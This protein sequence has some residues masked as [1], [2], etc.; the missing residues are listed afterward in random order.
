[1]NGKT[2][3]GAL[4][5][6]IA[7]LAT[8]AAVALAAPDLNTVATNRVH[9]MTATMKVVDKETNYDELKRMGGA[10]ATTYRIKKMDF[11]YKF[12]DKARFEA[13][14]LGQSVLLVYNGDMK[15]SKIPFRKDI[16]NVADEPG[17][18]QSLMDLGVF[19]RDYLASAYRPVYQ[20]TEN[21]FYV[22]KLEQRNTTNTSHEIVYVDPKTSV[23]NK[24]FSYNGDNKLTKEMRF[25]NVKQFGPGVWLPTRLEIWSQFGKRAAVQNI[26]NIQVNKGVQDSRFDIS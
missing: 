6:S 19:S 9:D 26:E 13:K 7:A 16:R 20:K 14:I 25:R 23:I 22:Y 24:K 8:I 12:P 11:E 1:M 4:A 10:F 15:M 5:I 2:N 18:K 17:Q 3:A 21:G